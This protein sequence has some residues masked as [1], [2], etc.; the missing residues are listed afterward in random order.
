M[1]LLLYVILTQ[2]TRL[3]LDGNRLSLGFSLACWFGLVP[4][5]SSGVSTP[6]SVWTSN[7]WLCENA[8]TCA[9]SARDRMET[10]CP[11]WWTLVD[12]HVVT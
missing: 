9:P 12:F 11:R 8:Q 6:F 2:P 5:R 10:D 3:L 4:I 1:V 7:W